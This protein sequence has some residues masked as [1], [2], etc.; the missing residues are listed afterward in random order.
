M[1][2]LFVLD[3][4]TVKILN[5]TNVQS[6]FLPPVA[7]RAPQTQ[8]IT[9]R[10]SSAFQRFAMFIKDNQICNCGAFLSEMAQTLKLNVTLCNFQREMCFVRL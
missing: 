2:H 8:S 1:K 3:S 5:K 10:R 7:C 4:E 9:R 6:L